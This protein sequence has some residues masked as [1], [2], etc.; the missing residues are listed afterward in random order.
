MADQD[1]DE[2]LF[3]G[4]YASESD[5]MIWLV[6]GPKYDD[7][8]DAGPEAFYTDRK[9]AIDDAKRRAKWVK[10]HPVRVEVS[11]GGGYD[12]EEWVEKVTMSS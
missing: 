6:S 7:D 11:A 12:A 8:D 9:A 4:V 3:I 1:E 2:E 5:P 10:D